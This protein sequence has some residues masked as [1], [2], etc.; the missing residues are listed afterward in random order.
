VSRVGGDDFKL[1]GFLFS[2]WFGR[3]WNVFGME[4]NLFED[5]C[6]EVF[7]LVVLDNFDVSS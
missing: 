7:L 6:L 1:S 3:G 5:S 4:D 2:E